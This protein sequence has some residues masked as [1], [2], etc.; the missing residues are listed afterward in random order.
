[1]SSDGLSASAQTHHDRRTPDSATV[2]ATGCRTHPPQR[3][4][5]PHLIASRRSYVINRA[6]RTKV[7]WTTLPETSTLLSWSFEETVCF[8]HS[9]R[10]PVFLHS[11]ECSAANPRTLPSPAA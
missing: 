4:S 8:D 11:P 5:A 1:M 10:P 3:L 7:Q 9:F 2:S 6:S